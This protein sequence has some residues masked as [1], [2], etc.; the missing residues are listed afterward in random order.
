M[1]SRYTAYV[2]GAI[3]H[4]VATHEPSTRHEID[5]KG[6]REWSKAAKWKGLEVHEVVGGADDETGEVEFTARYELKGRSVNH[7][8]RAEF[9]KINDTWFFV[10][11][12]MVKAPTV[13][14]EGPK[15]GRNDPCPCGSGK[16]YKKCCAA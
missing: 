15:V 16:K 12:T 2:I 4:V 5:E 3:D 8:E 1:R 13:V 6:A 10:D 14:R 9:K 7:R 11:G